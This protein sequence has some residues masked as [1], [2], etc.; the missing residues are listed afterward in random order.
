MEEVIEQKLEELRLLIGN[1]TLY[2]EAKK[3]R[4]RLLLDEDLLKEIQ[5][6]QECTNIYSEEYRARK[7]KLFENKDYQDYQK[8]ENEL[9]VLSLQI[10]QILNQLTGK[11]DSCFL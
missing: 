1:S 11:G 9:Y 3:H 7:K 6:L 10:N 8:F 2:Q 4:E 5:F